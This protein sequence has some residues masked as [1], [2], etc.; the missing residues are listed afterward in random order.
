[1]HSL[2]EFFS[3]YSYL[4]SSLLGLPAVILG[5]VFTD[6]L[7]KMMLLSGLL[8]VLFSPLSV[9]SQK[10][11]W[12]PVRLFG[13]PFGIEDVVV[14]FSLGSLIFLTTGGTVSNR[15]K[16]DLNWRLF[17]KRFFFVC[18]IGAAVFNLFYLL[19]KGSLLSSILTYSILAFILLLSRKTYWRVVFPGALIY[20]LYYCL[21]LYTTALISPAFFGIWNGYAIWGPR[22]Q[23]LPVEDILWVMSLAVCYPLIVLYASGAVLIRN[24]T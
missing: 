10:E 5:F 13:G 16:M 11:Y 18:L 1:M 24:D 20:T 3:S 22:I 15:L 12:N 9:L 7:R 23:G 19:G 4:L 14:S 2:R 21:I 6:K 8:M 17:L